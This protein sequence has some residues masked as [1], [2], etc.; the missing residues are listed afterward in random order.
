MKRIKIEL[1]SLGVAAAITALFAG[2]GSGQ[3]SLD[4]KYLSV[5]QARGEAAA[6]LGGAPQTAHLNTAA[7]RWAVSDGQTV[8]WLDARSGELLEVEFAP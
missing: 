2:S 8:A 7:H 6:Y 5:Q 1:W 4:S 3:E